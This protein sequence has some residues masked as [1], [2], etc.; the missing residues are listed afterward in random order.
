MYVTIVTNI[1]HLHFLYFKLFFLLCRL[2]IPV[3][4]S[5]YSDPH[6]APG[7]DTITHLFEWK[8]SDVKAECERFLG[9]NG[10][11]GVQVC[12]SLEHVFA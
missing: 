4:G 6:C 5:I 7:R 11:C 8:W 12:L 1:L 9:P 10:Y 2:V 3:S